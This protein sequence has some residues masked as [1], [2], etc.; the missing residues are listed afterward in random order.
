MTLLAAARRM[1][2][3]GVLLLGAA[4][5]LAGE[6]DQQ[7]RSSRRPYALVVPPDGTVL[8]RLSI[9]AVGRRGRKQALRLAAEASLTEPL[10]SYLVD[11]WRIDAE[12]YGLAAIPR[13][14]LVRYQE[15]ANERGQAARRIQSPELTADLKDGLV[16]WV[17]PDAVTACIWHRGTLTDWQAIPRANGMLALEQL[18]RHGVASGISQVIVRSAPAKDRS[19]A[20]SVGDACV[21]ALPAAEVQMLDDPI[22]GPGQ[23]RR[24][25]CTFDDFVSEQSHRPASGARRRGAALAT[26]AL[27]TALSWFLYLQLRDLEDQ[28]ARAEHTA[29][30]LKMQAGRSVR[31]ADR[32]GRLIGE[33]R[34]MQAL[35]DASVVTLLDNLAELMPATVR[36]AGMLQLDRRGVLTLDGLAQAERDISGFVGGLRRHPQV[37]G[38]RLQSV[39]AS[40]S[41]K[42]QE[43]GV[44]FRL[45]VRLTTPLWQPPT[46]EDV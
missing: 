12:Q 32:V 25:L 16:L 15:F 22:T 37:S 30:L 41:D 9:P 11:Y 43:Q 8:R 35:D 24:T 23:G 13:N 19:F 21:R 31:I 5:D 27:L 45:Q 20:Q 38:V 17:M 29:S 46:G 4:G 33:V 7:L 2:R 14:F 40:R 26:L 39:T 28:A 1:P 3:E 10:D 36:L 44:R 18:L 34:E 6:I 42:S